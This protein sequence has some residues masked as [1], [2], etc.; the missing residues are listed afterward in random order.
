M[1]ISHAERP[2]KVDEL[3]YALAVEL[4]STDFN[5]DNVP[6]ISTLLSCCQG[7]ITVDKQESAVRLIHFTLT[8]YLV[9][10]P[11]TFGRHH[12]TMAEMCLT[13]LNSEK[14]KALSIDPPPHT[15]D[16]PILEYCSLYW[17]VHA[18]RDLSE[19]ARSLALELFQYYDGHISA[20]LL[21]SGYSRLE[22]LESQDI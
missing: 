2:L 6:S 9:A 3:C 16:K 20:K 5:P 1:W 15:P 10:R 7:L 22:S 17:G 18:K 14:V 19:L 4:R 11:E 21:L 12:S 13:Y 8:E